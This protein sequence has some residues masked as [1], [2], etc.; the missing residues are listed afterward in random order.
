MCVY[1]TWN[2]L[3]WSI[4]EV[5]SK[6]YIFTSIGGNSFFYGHSYLLKSQALLA[7]QHLNL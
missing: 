6:P 4:L 1:I 2:I 3:S 5:C 7:Y